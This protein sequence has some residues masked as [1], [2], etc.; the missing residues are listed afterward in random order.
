MTKKTKGVGKHA[1]YCINSAA[2]L[3][4]FGLHGLNPHKATM[5]PFHSEPGWHEWITANMLKWV[6]PAGWQASLFQRK[7][8]DLRH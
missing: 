2:P 8:S 6:I 7:K 3:P 4:C 1:T 5:N